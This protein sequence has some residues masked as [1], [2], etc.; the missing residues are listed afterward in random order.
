MLRI[1]SKLL[2]IAQTPHRIWA[3]LSHALLLTVSS[4]S[5]LLTFLSQQALGHYPA[6]H[7]F[8]GSSH[9]YLSQ[10]QRQ[11]LKREKFSWPCSFIR[12]F[13]S[14]PQLLSIFP[15]AFFSFV[16]F[17]QKLEII[18][19][20]LLIFPLSHLDFPSAIRM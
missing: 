13:P 18:F 17:N 4:H 16:S 2:P 15:S 7:L 10:L 12:A 11:L 20:S 8:P 6:P 14:S 3:T 1:K 9:D 19:I 5:D